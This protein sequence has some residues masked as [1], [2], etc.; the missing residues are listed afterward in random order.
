MPEQ[1]TDG[2]G[3][4]GA[5][6]VAE[7]VERRGLPLGTAGARANPAAGH[8]VG[9]KEAGGEQQQAKDDEPQRLKQCQQ[10][11]HQ[12]QSEKTDQHWGATEAGGHQPGLGRTKGSRQVDH[13]EQTD[14]GLSQLPG[15]LHQAVADVV[16]QGDEGAH[17][18]KAFGKQPGQ[19][20]IAPVQVQ[21]DHYRSRAQ[22][23]GA[24]VARGRQDLPEHQGRRQGAAADGGER[25]SPAEK[26]GQ[27]PGEQ[28]AAHATNRVATDIE[29]H[30]KGDLRRLYLLGQIAHRHRRDPAQGQPHQHAQQ[31]DAVPALHPGRDQ[32]TDRGQ[33]QRRDHHIFA[34]VGIG[35]RAADEQ[36]QRQHGGGAGEGEAAG[37]R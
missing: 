10:Q 26:V 31:Q 30:G 18:Q 24:E 28:A 35:E 14:D 19:G 17:Q 2:A 34:A 11:T 22:R 4:A 7:E 6:V 13:G 15:R 36:P 37:R 21:R 5:D 27:H 20:G 1:A 16:E 23:Q 32:G 8:R 9:G 3:E 33:Q 29:P 25:Q 12:H